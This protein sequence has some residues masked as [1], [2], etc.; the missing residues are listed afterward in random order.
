MNKF[1]E[2]GGNV[3]EVDKL[4]MTPL[5]VAVQDIQLKI[6]DLLIKNGA[7]INLLDIR[8]RTPLEINAQYGNT[9]ILFTFFL[10]ISLLL[11]RINVI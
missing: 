11:T 7:K 3:N 8:G 9:E 4:S 2:S 10:I 1:I 6:V 5:H